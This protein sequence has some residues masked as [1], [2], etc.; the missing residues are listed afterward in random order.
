M[1]RQ[2][3]M[4]TDLYDILQVAPH[5][6]PEV[7]ESAYKRLALKYHPDVNRAPDAHERMRAL[8]QA[9]Q[10]LS[11]PQAR[12]RYDARRATPASARR[13]APKKRAAPKTKPRK[14][15]TWTPP[16]RPRKET[17]KEAVAVNDALVAQAV[18][19]ARIYPAIT[20]EILQRHL[21]LRY[22]RAL[23]L[24]ATLL[25]QGWIDDHGVWIAK[26]V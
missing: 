4:E 9:Y 17:V 7:I 26:A 19:L 20:S 2:P 14:R 21:G 10:I 23:N 5:A 16:P 22:P 11:D 1:N 6:E 12:A 8:N 15:E 13:A 18:A 25:E 24:F 3:V